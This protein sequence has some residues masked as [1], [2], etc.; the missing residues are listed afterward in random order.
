MFENNGKVADG[1][2]QADALKGRYEKSS[3]ALVPLLF[4]LQAR[5]GYIT[6][7]AER[8]AA[9]TLGVDP[10]IVH[11]TVSFY[12]LLFDKPVGK[13]LI[14]VC[15]NISCSLLG[16]ESL[17]DV[18][19]R[20]LGVKEK[21][22]TPDGLISFQRAECLGCCADAPAMLVGEKLF[23]KLTLEKVKDII[24]KIRNG[25]PLVNDT[26]LTTTDPLPDGA[27][28]VNFLIPEAKT[29]KV[30]EERGAYKAARKAIFEMTPDQI[31]EEVKNAGLR[32][33]GG[34]GFPAGVKWGFVPKD[35]P[36]ERYLCVNGDE[37]EPGTC[38]D[39]EILRR[40]P[41]RLIEGIIIAAKAI[42]VHKAYVYIRREFY[43]PRQILDEAIKEAYTA[44]YLGKNIFGSDYSLDVYTHPGA[45]A[46]ICGEETG[47]IESLEGKKGWPRIKPPFP[48]SIGLFGRP[49]IV[50]NVET[51]SNVP[52][53]ILNGAGRFRERGT[54]KSPGTKLFS[55]SGHIKRPGVY[56]L[57]M[58]FNLRDLI[59]GVAGGIREGHILKAVI[60]GGSSV[61][62]LKADEIDVALDFES[63]CQ[64]GSG[65]GSGGVI[66]MDDTVFMPWALEVIS[67]FYAHE[68]CGQCTPCREGTTWMYK[69]LRRLNR[70][71]GR[72]GDLE[73]LLDLANNI[74][75][76]TVCP[77]GAAAAWPVQAMIKKF[78]EEFESLIKK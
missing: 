44:G 14:Q 31:R 34:A 32:G 76:Q 58:G 57:P 20:E 17:L 67:R 22:V 47:L 42:G 74:E 43:E 53:I 10:R 77:L 1:V 60:P 63:V 61:Q 54:E 5:Y 13:I 65:L 28:S 6:P 15:H 8:E 41:H 62:V 39:R 36:G 59:Y 75:G 64:V 70:G 4:E 25:E 26:P 40:D 12:P 45:G 46:Y 2:I 48:A 30:A 9:E 24:A 35:V 7:E 73:T 29:L 68:S 55:I 21:E 38:K 52:F 27:V 11:A 78:S 33:Q 23:G 69:I 3:A 71:L 56:E 19:E 49:T 66:V 37:S 16:A 50:N 18:L 72:K 51:I